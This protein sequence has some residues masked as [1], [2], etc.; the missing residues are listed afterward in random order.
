MR[1]EVIDLK[2]GRWRGSVL[3]SAKEALLELTQSMD[4][5]NKMRVALPENWRKLGPEEIRECARRPEARLW[6]D[7]ARILWRVSAVG[8]D[9][10]YPYP[11]RRRHLVFDSDKTWAG[12]VPFDPPAELGDMTDLELQR[13]RDR[14]CDFGGRRRGYRPPL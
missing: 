13:L 3:V 11:L 2:S 8:P 4:P 6:T 7:D 1:P 9:T 14:I 12:L 5:G 10:D